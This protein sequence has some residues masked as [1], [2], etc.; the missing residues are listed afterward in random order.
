M[1]D[2]ARLFP[3]RS[4][5]IHLPD[6]ERV[7]GKEIQ[8]CFSQEARYSIF[9]KGMLESFK[10]LSTIPHGTMKYSPIVI[11]RYLGVLCERPRG[12]FL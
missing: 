5:D 2:E 10:P 1:G 9:I 6:R 11:H 4:P 7:F 3:E 8:L 12:G